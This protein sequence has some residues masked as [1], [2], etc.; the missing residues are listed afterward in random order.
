MLAAK[1][2][3]LPRPARLPISWQRPRLVRFLLSLPPAAQAT[4]ALEPSDLLLRGQLGSSRRVRR[5][6]PRRTPRSG[7]Q[8]TGGACDG[9]VSGAGL[10]AG[11]AADRG[12]GGE[13]LSRMSCSASRSLVMSPLI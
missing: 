8:R 12:G 2:R 7:R 9:G 13:I 10:R 1:C 11:A 4:L 5:V 3:S 6:W